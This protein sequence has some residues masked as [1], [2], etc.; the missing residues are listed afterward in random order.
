MLLPLL[1]LAASAVVTDTTR[2]IVSNHGREAGD[3]VVVRTADS[4]IVR[5]VFTDRNR[6]TRVELRY[7]LNANGEL[8]RG[9]QRPVLADGSAGAPTDGFEAGA[10]PVWYG[11]ANG[12]RRTAVMRP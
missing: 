3:L 9:E 8:V 7:Q 6:G 2:W 5:W 1:A 11:L 10:D 12:A 4:A